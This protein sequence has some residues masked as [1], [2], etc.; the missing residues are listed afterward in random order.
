MSL[1][2]VQHIKKIYKTR[3][4]GTQVEALKDIHFTVE[5]GEYVAIMGESGSGKSTLLN[6]LAMLDQPTEGRVY[7]NGTDTSTIKNKDASSFRREKLGFVFQDFNLLDTLSVKDN[8]LLPLVLS[9]RPVKEMMSKVD[10]VSRELGI[11]QLL[12]K[13]PY[14][15]S[16]GQKQRVAVARA[17]ITSPE[18][19]LADEPTGALDSHAAQMLLESFTSLNEELGATI[20][21]V[22]HDVFSASYCSRIL[23][24]KDGRIFNE[25]R[26]G[27]KSR[28]AFFQEILDVVTLMGGDVSNAK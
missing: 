12:E 28:K 19:L 10:S 13:Y 2:D 1:L 16:G 14:E 9:R 26:R 27:E 18:I 17:I 21:M 7:L 24:L 25:I 23:F 11:H 15:I 22:T 6:I 3:F 20:L 5:N 8:I 4:Q